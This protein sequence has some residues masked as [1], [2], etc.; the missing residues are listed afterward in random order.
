MFGGRL[1]FNGVRGAHIRR[2]HTGSASSPD[3]AIAPLK[4]FRLSPGVHES[5]TFASEINTAR[6]RFNCIERTV[7]WG[8]SFPNFQII[9]GCRHGSSGPDRRRSCRRRIIRL[10]CTTNTVGTGNRSMLSG[11]RWTHLQSV[12]LL[13]VLRLFDTAKIAAE[14]G[15]TSPLR[16]TTM[17]N[18]FRDRWRDRADQRH[19]R[20]QSLELSGC[21]R[22]GRAT[23][24]QRTT[25]ELCRVNNSATGADRTSNSAGLQIPTPRPRPYWA[26]SAR[27]R[28]R[29]LSRGRNG[30]GSALRVGPSKTHE[31][32]PISVN[33]MA[34]LRSACGT[35]GTRP[36]ST[37]QQ[38]PHRY[39]GQTGAH[40]RG[41][42]AR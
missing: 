41:Q 4:L 18:A 42:T 9:G 23:A 34:E 35:G 32:E 8:R 14:G 21:R 3:T 16:K 33:T 19:R 7:R 20:G 37:Q 28:D 31:T 25:G 10:H 40:Q 5:A 27:W 12:R 38:T 11:V 22:R 39:R 6:A 2:C 1:G 29:L 36:W 24:V 30:Q 17:R 26:P 15:T 13:G